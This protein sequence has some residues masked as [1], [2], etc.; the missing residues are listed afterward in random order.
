MSRGQRGVGRFGFPS[1][2]FTLIPEDITL[3]L[4]PAPL[5]MGVREK[6]PLSSQI[7]S[8]M[9]C[10]PIL[11]LGP[12]KLWPRQSTFQGQPGQS[13]RVRPDGSPCWQTSQ[14]RHRAQPPTAWECCGA[15]LGRVCILVCAFSLALSG[16]VSRRHLNHP[17]SLSSPRAAHGSAP[18]LLVLL[19]AATQHPLCTPA[20]CAS[21][22]A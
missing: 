6:R 1:L 3:D 22:R 17:P 8:F 4:S 7:S 9:G 5:N 16:W 10:L 15:V 14:L 11:F 18:L 21:R 12:L 19:S 13:S 2:P 20:P